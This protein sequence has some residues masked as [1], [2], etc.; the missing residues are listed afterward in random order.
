MVP[1]VI[2]AVAFVPRLKLL[3][4]TEDIK[5]PPS[6]TE[7]TYRV[8]PER[9]AVPFETERPFSVPPVWFRFPVEVVRP[10]IVPLV[11]LAEPPD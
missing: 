3:R 11:M 7:S 5:S 6:I 10:E 1:A 4:L 8:P 2:I 9:L